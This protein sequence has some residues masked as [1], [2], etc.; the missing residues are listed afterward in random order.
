MQWTK[1]CTCNSGK[2][3][4]DAIEFNTNNLRMEIVC[5]KCH[6]TICWWPISTEQVVSIAAQATKEKSLAI[7]TAT[8]D[9]NIQ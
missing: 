4:F 8:V 2:T 3:N 1:E 6:G 9:R 7:P 5:G